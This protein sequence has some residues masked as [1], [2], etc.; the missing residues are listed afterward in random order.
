MTAL[1]TTEII[2]IE[3]DPEGVIRISK[4]RV[5][6]DTLIAAFN[7]GATP[8]EIAQQYPSVPLADIYSVIG[9]YLRRRSEVEAYLKRRRQQAEQ[10]RKE[11]ESRFSPIGVR[12]RLMARRACRT[13]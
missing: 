6:L 2:P 3:T 1:T 11:N 12:E 8:E 5:T 7:E 10:V 9:Y 13:A 4:T